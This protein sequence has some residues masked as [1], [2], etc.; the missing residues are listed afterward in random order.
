V[1]DGFGVLTSLSLT[2]ITSF[3]IK[4]G[5]TPSAWILEDSNILFI[6]IGSVVFWMMF[7]GDDVL[8]PAGK[9]VP[10]NARSLHYKKVK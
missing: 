5:S 9:A 10:A 1:T 7:S 6:L 2:N 3:C 8:I 4:A